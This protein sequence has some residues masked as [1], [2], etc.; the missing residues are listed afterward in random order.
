[1]NTTTISAADFIDRIMTG[2]RFH[3]GERYVVVG[4]VSLRGAVLQRP[5][6]LHGFL[7]EGPVDLSDTV[8]PGEFDLSDC[9]F[10]RNVKL[11]QMHV[12][13][14]IRFRRV[15]V[16]VEAFHRDGSG[17]IGIEAIGLEADGDVRIQDLDCRGAVHASGL[18]VGGAAIWQ[19]IEGQ[20]DRRPVPVHPMQHPWRSQHD[21]ADRQVLCGVRPDRH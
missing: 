14:S 2:G 21:G 5:L 8:V 15:R 6:L 3:V 19:N 9:R 20:P 12:Q 17:G 13:G 4:E 11:S 18:S 16:D 7:F 1:M 10:R